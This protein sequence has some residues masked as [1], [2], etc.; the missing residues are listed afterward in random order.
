MSSQP[1]SHSIFISCVSGEFENTGAP[2]AGLRKQLRGYLVRTRCNVRIQEDFPQVAPGTLQKLSEEIRP[3]AV[4]IHLVGEQCGTI[5]KPAEV[6]EFLAAEQDFLANHPELRDSLGNFD[7][8]SYTQ[9]EAYIALHYGIPLLVY[10]TGNS[11]AQQT[12]LDRLKQCGR[13][14]TTITSE[15]D[16]FG[17]LIGDLHNNLPVVPEI[18]RKIARTQLDKHAPRVL[19]GRENELAE[20]DAAWASETLNVYTLVAGGGAGKTSLVFH[21]VQTRFGG[22]NRKRPGV[23]RYFELE[24]LQPRHRREPTDLRRPLHRQS[25]RFFGD[26][27]PTRKPTNEASGSQVLSAS[28]APVVLDGIEPLQYPPNDPQAGRVKDPALDT[29]LREL[30]ND[31]PGLVVITTREHLTDLEKY[32]TAEEKNLDKLPKDAAVAHC[33]T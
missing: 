6:A 25:T 10:S 29:L 21:W 20:L 33:G 14:T 12:H 15:T 5:A 4:V 18:T 26:E 2:F 31:N 28:T 24:L 16:L 7:D 3:S 13:H 9:W 27:D 17:K 8:I 19:F 32:P 23:E 30:A 1:T 11:A 22:T